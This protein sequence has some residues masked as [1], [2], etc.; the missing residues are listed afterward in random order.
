[1][2]MRETRLDGDS[3]VRDN[4]FKLT[5]HGD[6]FDLSQAPFEEIAISANTTDAA[7]VSAR[8]KLQA[9]LDELPAAPAAARRKTL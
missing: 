4:R 3:Y 8:K 1:M 5:N 9:I 7:A 6:L 2:Y